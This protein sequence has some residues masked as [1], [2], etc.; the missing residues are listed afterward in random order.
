MNYQ[1]HITSYDASTLTQHSLGSRQSCN[2]NLSLVFRFQIM[3]PQYRHA[4]Y[5]TLKLNYIADR[6]WIED[7]IAEES[8]SN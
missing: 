7:S 3:H 1:A 5:Q 2:T 8:S 6:R 4:L